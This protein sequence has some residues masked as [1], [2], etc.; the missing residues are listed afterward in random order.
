MRSATIALVFFYL[1]CQPADL[2]PTLDPNFRAPPLELHYE[3]RN[4]AH[5]FQGLGLALYG[6]QP[7]WLSRLAE[8][9]P[10]FVRLEAGPSW[11]SLD[12]PP[13]WNPSEYPAYIENHFNSEDPDRMKKFQESF[14]FFKEH[15]IQVI[16]VIYQQP[17][18]WLE[19]DYMHTFKAGA[20]DRLVAFWVALLQFFEKKGMEVQF[21]ELA[22]E[23]EGN[24]NG[25][26]PAK[27]YFKMVQRARLAFNSAGLEHIGIL[28]PGLSS[29]DLEQIPLRWIQSMSAQAEHSLAGFSLHAWDE[30][31]A[32]DPGLS[33]MRNAWKNPSR[34]LEKLNPGKP[35]FVTEYASE[36]SRLRPGGYHS[37]AKRALFTASDTEPYALRLAA[38]TLIHI[39]QAAAVT[40]VWR[41]SD[42]NGDDSSWGLIRSPERGGGCR[43]AFKTLRFLSEHLPRNARVIRPI[44]PGDGLVASLL[45]KEETRYHWIGVNTGPNMRRVKL[46]LDGTIPGTG[47]MVLFQFSGQKVVAIRGEEGWQLELPPH[48]IGVLKWAQ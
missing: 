13:P 39:N 7:R 4:Q 41:L 24:W 28:G 47:L 20:E 10:Q 42:L 25:H 23:P 29:L 33:S 44:D 12:S 17:Y 8:L 27:R 21:V 14:R 19:T 30:V 6:Q 2:D 3:N 15:N 40:V 9:D 32:E 36:V 26:I 22:N 38:N 5:L 37:P 34:A 46:E 35:V 16:L 45:L 11:A 31:L 1:G 18:D 48:S 43:P